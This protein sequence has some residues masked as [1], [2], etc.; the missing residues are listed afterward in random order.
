[1]GT[2]LTVHNDASALARR[3]ERPAITS[4]MSFEQII[5]MGDQLVRTGFLPNHVKTGAQAAAIVLAG[6]ELGMPPMRA[7]R[8]LVLVQGKVVEN[9]DSQLSRFKAD[10]GRAVWKRLDEQSATLW[11]RH[12]NGDEHE[13]TFTMGDA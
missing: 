1:M 12:P 4:G 5:Y 10:G 9:A 3:E 6:Q 7:L 8:S 13:E 11:L 2:A